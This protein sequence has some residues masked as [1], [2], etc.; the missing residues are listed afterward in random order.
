MTIRLATLADVPAVMALEERNYIGNLSA[1]ELRDGFISILHPREWFNEAL[2]SGGL[3]VASQA[4][5]TVTGFMAV[6][7]PPA[8]VQTASSPII[9]AMLELAETLEVNGKPIAQQRYA[10]RG[11]VLIDR[12]ARGA[13]LY[14]DFNAIMHDSYSER[15]DVGV[16]FVA[17]ENER[18]VHTT[19]TKLGAQ[20]LA[21]FEA[22]GKRYHFMAF[23]F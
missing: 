14:S 9:R 1:S 6:T 23:T 15:F 22:N 5:G 2:E 12:A 18:S 4:D 13:G 8:D 10:F 19:T 16:L 3:H 11:P 17:A 21:T 7:S 20:S